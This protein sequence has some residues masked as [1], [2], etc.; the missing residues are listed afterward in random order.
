[1]PHPHR[2]LMI[3]D[4]QQEYFDGPLVIEYP[5]RDDSFARILDALTLAEEQGMPV[6]VVQHENPV[7]SAAFASGSA[8]QELHPT[9]AGRLR[10]EQ[11]RIVK[12][13]ASAFDET[14]LASWCRE[15][16][17]DTLTL[18]GY[19]TN[20]CILATAAS[21]APHGLVVEVLSDATGAINLSNEI[22]TASARQ[23]HE[24]IMTLLHSN[25]AAVTT[26]EE[27]TSNVRAGTACA[28]SNLISSATN[29]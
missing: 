16:G 2:A 1:M 28:R 3:V 13:F 20:N 21:A 5:S 23:V 4:V 22:G 27:W 11:A 26:T 29:G 9:L 24:T 25:L 6:V 19:M 12:R 15:Q 8:R 18:A 17:I 7:R 10:P 14:T